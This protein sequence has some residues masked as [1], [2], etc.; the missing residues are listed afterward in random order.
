[1]KTTFMN[2]TLLMF[3]HSPFLV[4]T[5]KWKNNY[6][7]TWFIKVMV[8][9][10]WIDLKWIFTQKSLKWHNKTYGHRRHM[11]QELTLNLK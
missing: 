5:G 9:T 8:Y 10:Y 6:K 4:L 7:H 2:T 11:A 3:A 1:M